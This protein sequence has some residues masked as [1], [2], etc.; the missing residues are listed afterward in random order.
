MSEVP[1]Y[2]AIDVGTTTTRMAVVINDGVKVLESVP[3]TVTF[4]DH[5]ILV[6]KADKFSKPDNI[7][8]RIKRLLGCQGK[9]ATLDADKKHMPFK[10]TQ[11]VGV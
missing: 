7:I 9:E 2:I 11:G 8:S 3:T 5:G 10:I 6:G 4:A 1:T